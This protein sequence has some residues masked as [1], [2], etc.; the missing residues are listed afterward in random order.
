MN[1]IQ[2]GSYVLNG[3]LISYLVFG[4]AGWLVLRYYLRNMAEWR[5]V[6]SIVSNAFWLWVIVWKLSYLIFQPLEV[7]QRP[8]VL[9][10]FDGGERGAWIASLLTASYIW[11][12]AKKLKGCVPSWAD[13]ITLYLFAGWSAYQMLWFIFGGEPGWVHA[14]SGILSGTFLLLLLLPSLRGTK[15]NSVKSLVYAVWFSIGQVLLGFCIPGRTI[16][17]LSFS[18]QQLLFLLIAV[19]LIGWNWVKERRSQGGLHE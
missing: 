16:L 12:K 3:Q 14:A 13:I 6:L 1:N 4:A 17:L 18:N 10:Y 7:I 9:L 8:L 19:A 11:M 5:V 2:I 15:T